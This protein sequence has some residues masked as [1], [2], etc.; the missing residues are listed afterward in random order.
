MGLK[1][2]IFIA[3]TVI[4]VILFLTG[5]AQKWIVYIVNNY[6][7]PTE[8]STF[9]R[10]QE[11]YQSSQDSVEGPEMSPQSPEQ[12]PPDA[13]KQSSEQESLRDSVVVPAQPAPVDIVPVSPIPIILP[14]SATDLQCKVIK[15]IPVHWSDPPKQ[16][17]KEMIPLPD[18]YGCG[19]SAKNLWILKNQED[20]MYDPWITHGNPNWNGEMKGQKWIIKRLWES[21]AMNFNGSVQRFGNGQF[22]PFEAR[23]EEEKIH[24]EQKKYNLIF[25]QWVHKAG[26]PFG[27]YNQKGGQTKNDDLT[28]IIVQRNEDGF[29][30]QS[31]NYE[32]FEVRDKDTVNLVVYN[33][34]KNTYIMANNS[35]TKKWDVQ[36]VPNGNFWGAQ[37]MFRDTSLQVK[38]VWFGSNS[39]EFIKDDMVA[40]IRNLPSLQFN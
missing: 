32:S 8:I 2:N 20:D 29:D 39:E 17:T 23:T 35:S 25:V 16:Q 27:I 7:I 34:G 9:I 37:K 31:T 19:S 4:C 1:L 6:E 15:Q 18:G 30:I 3:I 14:S 12:V 24:L 33:N 40:Y 22:F 10:S 13:S 11:W 28:S 21:Q 26:G 5:H 38:V 36:T